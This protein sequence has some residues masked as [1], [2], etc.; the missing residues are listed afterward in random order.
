MNNYPILDQYYL[1]EKFKK[2]QKTAFAFKIVSILL[3]DIN[4]TRN[5]SDDANNKLY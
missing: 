2:I 1:D 3:R 5:K 4:K